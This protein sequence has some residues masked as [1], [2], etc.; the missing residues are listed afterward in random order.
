MEGYRRNLLIV[1]EEGGGALKGTI[2]GTGNAS[3]R[4][5]FLLRRLP[6][7]LLL[8]YGSLNRKSFVDSAGPPEIRRK[9][10]HCLSDEE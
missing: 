5:R 4:R 2:F 8:Q 9:S 6:R 1:K 3:S 10:R 7:I